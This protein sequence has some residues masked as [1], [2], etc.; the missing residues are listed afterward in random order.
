VLELAGGLKIALERQKVPINALAWSPDGHRLATGS[1]DGTV[2]VW[3]AASGRRIYAFDGHSNEVICMAWSPDGRRLATGSPDRTV[4]VWDIAD[5]RKLLTLECSN[6]F[7]QSVSWSPNGQQLAIA[8]IGGTAKIWDAAS[9]RELLTLK[10]HSGSPQSVSWSPDG[11]RLAT[12]SIDGKAKVW[13]AASGRELLTLKGHTT[14]VRSVSW[15]PDGQR[16][17]TGSLD[18]TVKVWERATEETRQAWVR[19]ERVLED[20]LTRNAFHLPKAQGF[21]QDW[22]LLLPVPLGLGR[23]VPVLATSTLGHMGAP[24][25]QGRLL[26]ASALIP[27]SG[28]QGLD[29]QQLPREAELRPRAG[30]RVWVVGKELVWKEYRCP[31]VVLNFN[32]VLGRVTEWSVAYAVC[33]LECDRPRNDLWLQVVSDDQAKVYLNGR[34][35]YQCRRT[36]ELD[37]LDTVGPVDLLQGTNV[38][39]FKVVNGLGGWNGCVRLVDDDGQPAKGITVKL[40]PEP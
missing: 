21:I 10:G 14:V 27:E 11:R 12:G 13:E 15:S 31:E 7:A 3:D 29:L 1:G 6:D 37:W 32:A 22:L 4:K 25:G 26:A 28:E 30:E 38:L 19:Q 18:G 8:C 33:Y 39:V 17:A 23:G 5:G 9:G 36:R 40:T 24:L 16:L 2:R 20:L 34:E 35:I